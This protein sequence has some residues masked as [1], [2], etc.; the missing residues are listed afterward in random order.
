MKKI[1]SALC[2]LLVFSGALSA[3]SFVDKG[4]APAEYLVERTL[5]QVI[6]KAHP[7]GVLEPEGVLQLGA[8]VALS[9][10]FSLQ[11]EGGYVTSLLGSEFWPKKELQGYRL[12][13]ELRMFFD[14]EWYI[15]MDYM[16]KDVNWKEETT[17]GFDCNLPFGQCAYT[18]EVDVQ[19]NRFRIAYH[20]KLGY[21]FRFDDRFIFDLYGGLGLRRI[22]NETT[23]IPN[24]AIE[25]Q[26]VR[27]TIFTENDA[28]EFNFI[29]VT[30]GFKIGYI[31]NRR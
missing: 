6:L 30:G 16:I 17:L 29:S 21:Q 28:P 13:G 22:S 10:F 11:V 24:N 25:F 4:T 9:P 1:V 20:V 18:K 26:S 12:R 3:Q 7:L 8:E 14:P 19:R 5:G 31:L 15:A 27:R 23:L 2:L